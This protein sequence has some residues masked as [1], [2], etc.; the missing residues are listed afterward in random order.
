MADHR[1]GVDY[2]SFLLVGIGAV[3]WGGI[4]LGYLLS[5]DPVT[6]LTNWNIVHLIGSTIGGMIG[7]GLE[8][9][10]YTVVGLAGVA[11]LAG[12]TGGYGLLSDDRDM[13]SMS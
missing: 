7:R 10:I 8:A 9:T 13:I 1:Y 4:G 3:S 5:G 12:V 11:D 2:V 6:A